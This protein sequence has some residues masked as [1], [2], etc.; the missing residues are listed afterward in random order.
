MLGPRATPYDVLEHYRNNIREQTVN[1]QY[2]V[3]Q[4]SHRSRK[5]TGD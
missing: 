1:T 2:F 5:A 3:E 4:W